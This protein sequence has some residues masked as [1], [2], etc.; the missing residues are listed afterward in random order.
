MTLPPLGPVV[1]RPSTPEGFAEAVRLARH[2]RWRHIGLASSLAGTALFAASVL[3]TMQAMSSADRLSVT[4]TGPDQTTGPDPAR[5]PVPVPGTVTAT[6]GWPA[7]GRET[8]AAGSQVAGSPWAGRATGP[9]PAGPTPIRTPAAG[10]WEDYRAMTASRLDAPESCR[11]TVEQQWCGALLAEAEPRRV[12]FTIWLCPGATTEPELRFAS[13]LEIE[14]WVGRTWS[15]TEGKSFR[16]DG[17]TRSVD[18]GECFTWSVV[19]RDAVSGTHEV[20]AMVGAENVVRYFS[21]SVTVP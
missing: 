3:P 14:V 13:D 15:W 12:A 16:P 5:R 2:R 19:W 4:T 8:A 1:F 18:R 21:T 17:H 9:G 10:G 7:G 11:L 6:P 20:T